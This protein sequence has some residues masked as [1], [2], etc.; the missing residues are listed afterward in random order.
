MVSVKDMTFGYNGGNL[1]EG[2]NLQ[3]EKGNIYGLLGLNGAGKTTLMKLLTGLLFPQSGDI[4]RD[5]RNPV[6][7]KSRISL[8]DLCTA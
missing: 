6:S 5:G 1:F 3:M 2:L 7:E 4:F 8:P